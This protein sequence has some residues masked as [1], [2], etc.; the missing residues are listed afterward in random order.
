MS[1]IQD[2]LKNTLRLL[3]IEW[4]EDLAQYKKKF[5]YTSIAD[6]K[7]EGVCWYPVL[8]K[9]MKIGHGERVIVDLERLDIGYAHVFQSGKSVSIFSTLEG[10]HHQRVSGVINQVK[11]DV[12]IITIQVDEVPEWMHKGKMGIDLLFDEASYR[13]MEF[14]M[15]SV[16]KADKGRIGELKNILLGESEAALDTKILPSTSLLNPSQNNAVSLVTQTKDI[17]IIHGPPGTGKTTTLVQ[18]I[19]HS[20]KQYPQVLVCAPSNAAVDLVV[21]KLLEENIHTLRLGHPAR[22]DDAILSQTLDAKLAMH[23]SFRDLKKARKAADEYRKLAFKYKRSFGPEERA[24]RKRLLDEAGRLK[25]EAEQ[26]EDYITYDVFQKTQ[27]FA[28]T[29]VGASA[30]ALKGVEFPVVFIDEAGQGLEPAT[31]IPILKAKKVVMA[32]DHCQLPPTIKSYEAAKAGLS[33]TLFEKVIKRQPYVSQML[34]EQYRMPETIMGFSSQYFYHSGLKAAPHTLT[35]YLSEDEPVMEFIDT[36]GAGFQ[37]QQEQESLSTYNPEEATFV[38]QHLESL[39]KRVGIAKIKTN[40]WTIG[41]IAPYRAQV[42]KFN[43]LI[44]GS[45]AFPN[46]RSFSEL[47]TIDSID[48]FQG[49]ERDIIFISLVRSNSKGEIGFLSDV[50]RMNVALT[51]AKRKLVV[52]GDS[53]TLGS[54]EFYREF[55]DY[56]EEKGCYRSVY[57]FLDA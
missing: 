18:A 50:R 52:V 44:F 1:K 15:K 20:L 38:L 13:E 29:L 27:V 47:L 51:R 54:H 17:A 25:S 37:E 41:L 33:E 57:E 5:M 28:T 53:A 56:M 45:Y 11:K 19:V 36:A 31:W 14:A 9:K 3:K 43:E 30:H 48:G 23:E 46:L 34:Q 2:Q 42:R 6:K 49:Q 24:Q 40:A 12:M 26:L 55:L 8:L 39:L 4:E 10:F 21:E 16:I 32:G 35:H 7:E 22:V